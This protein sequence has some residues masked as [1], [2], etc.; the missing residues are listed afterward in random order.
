MSDLVGAGSTPGEWA[1]VVSGQDLIAF[2]AKRRAATRRQSREAR[3]QWGLLGA[4]QLKYVEVNEMID[5]NSCMQNPRNTK[6]RPMS[7]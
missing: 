1:V 5:P 2:E 4:A 7:E 6:Y 3:I